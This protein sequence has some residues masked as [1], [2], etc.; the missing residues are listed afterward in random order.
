MATYL[1]DCFTYLQKKIYGALLHNPKV[2]NNPKKKSKT[3]NFEETPLHL[4]VA[5]YI[6]YYFLFIIG[7]VFENN[8][9]RSHF[10]KLRAKRAT[11][12]L[13]ENFNF[14]AKNEHFFG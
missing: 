9:K 7:T 1:Q 3:T 2:K 13:K 4:A 10:T 14:R 6:G 11:F 5:G 12:I 8:S